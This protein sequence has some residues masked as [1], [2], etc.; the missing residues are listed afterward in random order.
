MLNLMFSWQS[1]WLEFVVSYLP[2]YGLVLLGAFFAAE[3]L[4]SPPPG[5]TA[6]RS[7]PASS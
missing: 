7:V 2:L 3:T 6:T 4:N 1:P 5:A